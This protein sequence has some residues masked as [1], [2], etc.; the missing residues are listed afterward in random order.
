M[1]YFLVHFKKTKMSDL[2]A[3]AATKMLN[4]PVNKKK[5]NN[6]RQTFPAARLHPRPP[7]HST[8]EHLLLLKPRLLQTP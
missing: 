7:T 3:A 8:E 2:N 5:K 6:P 4:H 1:K